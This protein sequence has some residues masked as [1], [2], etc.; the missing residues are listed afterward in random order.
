[1]SNLNA[2]LVSITANAGTWPVADANA[3]TIVLDSTTGTPYLVK[4]LGAVRSL[5]NLGPSP[6]LSRAIV[7]TI[8]PGT[9]GSGKVTYVL[10]IND[11]SGAA[12]PKAQLCVGVQ[13]TVGPGPL[14]L[15]LVTGI[16]ISS[17]INAT[18]TSAAVVLASDATGTI[19]FEVVAGPAEVVTVLA[20]TDAPAGGQ[21]FADAGRVLP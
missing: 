14:S 8:T 12:V 9:V 15:N 10:K 3:G 18:G 21:T 6:L 13:L 1:M 19:E 5:Q 7:P 17:A 16:G 20:S 4:V 11:G 2:A